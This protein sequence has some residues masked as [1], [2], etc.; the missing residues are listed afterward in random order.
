M[1]NQTEQEIVELIYQQWRH[2]FAPLNPNA[3]AALYAEDAILF[4]SRIPPYIGRTAIES[5]FKDL[6]Q[7]LYTGVVF[8]P[9]HIK[10]VTQDVISIA[11][12]ANF[13]RADQTPLELRITHVL[14]RRENQWQIVSH[15]VSPKQNL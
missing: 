7:G 11:G 2:H 10:R 12:S 13:Q 4:G 15:H 1:N 5:Y 3:L 14:V 8:I 6:P 9:D